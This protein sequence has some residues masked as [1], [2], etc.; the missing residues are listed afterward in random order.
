M[1][2]SFWVFVAALFEFFSVWPSVAVCEAQGQLS[3]TNSNGLSQR[4]M[5]FLGLKV[6]AGGFLAVIRAR[7]CVC[8]FASSPGESLND[9]EAFPHFSQR[10]QQAASGRY[11]QRS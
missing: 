4:K 11:A 1:H 10:A 6:E 9:L 2:F 3:D 8:A 5:W 7:L